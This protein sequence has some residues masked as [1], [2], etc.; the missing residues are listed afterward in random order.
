MM[1][2]LLIA[3]LT[4]PTA[5][6][7]VGLPAL[8]QGGGARAAGLAGAETA[9]FAAQALN[10]AARQSR[11]RSVAF[12]HQASI[13]HIRQ[14]HLHLT[15]ARGRGTWGLS[16]QLWQANDLER[17]TGPSAEPLGH[18]GVYE[19][20]VGLSY[21]R[22]MEQTR[23]GLQLKFIHQAIFTQNASGLAADLG[24]MRDISAS[25]RLGATVRNLGRMNRLDQRETDLPLE[26]RFG[27]A[28]VG[29]ADLLVAVEAQK[30]RGDDLTLHLGGEYRGGEHLRLRAGYQTTENR[31]LSAGVGLAAKQWVIDYAYVPFGSGLGDA[32]WLSLQLESATP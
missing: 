4:L 21:A 19:G 14:N 5:L 10:P 1:A 8:R 15:Q 22:Q 32:H 30:V 17:R 11:G 9:L 7:A 25:L 26:A 29:R 23:L 27:A 2:L 24:L 16:A 18:F 6:A 12:N 31:S 3:L 13:Q 28:Y 20:A